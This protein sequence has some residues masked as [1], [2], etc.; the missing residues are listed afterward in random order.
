[1]TFISVIKSDK[2]I[3]Y[4]LWTYFQE[5]VSSSGPFL[6]LPMELAAKCLKEI[7][8]GELTYMPLLKIGHLEI[9]QQSYQQFTFS[10][11]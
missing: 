10:T 9:L 11:K 6:P 8:E 4:Y 2:I 1:M 5:G 7:F 3:I